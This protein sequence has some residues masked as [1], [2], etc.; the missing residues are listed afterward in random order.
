LGREKIFEKWE[1]G[2]YV[3]SITVKPKD[4][5]LRMV[6]ADIR[7]SC[8]YMMYELSVKLGK[9][10]FCWKTDCIYYRKTAKNIKTVQDYFNEREM[11]YKQLF[12]DETDRSAEVEY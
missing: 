2:E 6:Y 3:E 11:L 10:F 12:Y 7:Y 1:N 5:Q 4:E 8:F 9:D